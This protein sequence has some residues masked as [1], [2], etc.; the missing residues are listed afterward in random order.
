M[1]R[2]YIGGIIG[3]DPLP[4]G[5]VRPGVSN[6]GSLGGDGPD[7]V[8]DADFDSVVLLLNVDGTT[9]TDKSSSTHTITTNGDTRVDATVK[10]FGSGSIEF[11]GATDHLSATSSSDFTF[12]TGDF[13][14]EV[15][16]K[17][18]N[19]A[20]DRDMTLFD[21]GTVNTPGHLCIF[22]DVNNLYCRFGTSVTSLNTTWTT[23]GMSNNNWNH[24]AIVRDSGTCRVFVN[25]VQKNSGTRSENLTATGCRI[26]TLS[27]YEAFY[28]FDGYLD[29][30][31][32]TKGV[33]RYTSNFNP[34]TSDLTN[35]VL[36]GT[37]ELR[38]DGTDGSGSGSTTTDL[39]DEAHTGIT[40]TDVTAGTTDAGV[41]R[42]DLYGG[43]KGYLDFTSSQAGRIVTL[44][45]TVDLSSGDFTIE[46]WVLFDTISDYRSF[47]RGGSGTSAS[48]SW[49]LQT[50]GSKISFLIGGA[51]TYSITDSKTV[52]TNTW[53][54]VALSYVSST[55]TMT[56]S[57]DGVVT[58]LTDQTEFSNMQSSYLGGF[59]TNIELGANR[60]GTV[61]HDGLLTDVRFTTGVALYPDLGRT[62]PI[63]TAALPTP[64]AGATRPTRKWGGLVGRSIF[65]S[66]TLD[67][68]FDSVVLLLDGD[69]TSG[70]T[71]FTD[72]SSSP[73]TIT[74]N[75]NTQVDT[76]VKKFGTGSIEFD[77]TGDYLSIS[78]SED[79]NMGS[80]DFTA[81]CWA[82]FDSLSTA[83]PF[84]MGQWSGN[85][86][87]TTL[88]WA[89]MLSTNTGY[90][91]FITSSNGSSVL[92]DLSTSTTSFSLSTSTWYHIAAVR[93]G[94]SFKIFVDGVERA[95]T[96]NSSALY[97]ATNAFTIGA[98]SDGQQQAMNGYLD[99]IRITKGVARYSSSFFTPPTS[100][101]SAD[102]SDITGSDD[103]VLLLDG[104]NNITDRSSSGHTIS[105]PVSAAYQSFGK[106]NQAL[107]FT[108]TYLNGP[109]TTQTSDFQFGTDDFTLESWIYWPSGIT[110]ADKCLFD[111]RTASNDAGLVWFFQGNTS[112]TLVHRVYNSNG[113]RTASSAGSLSLNAWHHV[114]LVR[115]GNT[116]TYFTD[117]QS[118][119][120]FTFTGS[121][122]QT[123]SNPLHIGARSDTLAGIQGY[124]DDFRVTKG[125]ALYPFHP[126]A[127][128]LPTTGTVTTLPNTGILS[129]AEHYQSKL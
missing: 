65:N 22:A 128:A 87:G 74:V 59:G 46:C 6:L 31:R 114:A 69:G 43:A 2:K 49:Q 19:G 82:Y 53:Y 7:T 21:N 91:R 45:T 41:T 85:V 62:T 60:G 123:A 54:H 107:D 129:L 98:E 95:S 63:P 117:G 52:T 24:L 17:F 80:G 89:I 42:P 106:F 110:T 116:F 67:A 29:D 5:S 100:A 127:S 9:I 105:W 71:T 83:E 39:S 37:V 90:V 15:W 68:N 11:D 66:T 76:A 40:S 94:N 86:G 108:S 113:L 55:Y 18:R 88:N 50:Y 126:P 120:S 118:V 56:L 34:P 115:K 111:S 72:K 101:L 79:F 12:G 51:S 73:H 20:S 33:A 99:D 44:P 125:A 119:G 25:G 10:K 92:F 103:V 35:T 36:G 122:N 28:A 13:T 70:S 14:I 84:I 26:G 77:G 75:G 112:G 30:Y 78:D 58:T 8:L 61:R 96:T 102:V 47:M 38:M 23:L 3:A 16:V 109:T 48:G 121:V 4:G 27:G 1:G 32:I 93:N 104:D 124:V 81:E 64:V 97:N 57:V